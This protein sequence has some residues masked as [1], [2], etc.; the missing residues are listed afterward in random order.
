M[1]RGR[2]LAPAHRA[3][4]VALDLAVLE[5]A[6]FVAL[7][8]AVSDAEFDLGV[9]VA[10]V[11]RQGDDRHALLGGELGQLVDLALVEQALTSPFQL[12][13]QDAD[14]L[15]VGG[16]SPTEG[17][18]ATEGTTASVDRT[19]R[20]TQEA[21][22][23]EGRSGKV[24]AHHR[25]LLVLVSLM[26]LVLANPVADRGPWPGV[27][28]EAAFTLV[29]LSAAY[30]LRGQARALWILLGL[31]VP[32][33][34]LRWL[35]R[36]GIAGGVSASLADGLFAVLLAVTVWTMVRGLFHARRVTAD[37]IVSAVTVYLMLGIAFG[38]LYAI[39][40]R[41]RPAALHTPAAMTPG[42]AAPW[43][44]AMYFSFVTLTTLGYGDITPAWP[45][46]RMIAALE[47]AVGPIYLTI[48]VARL[49]TL[50]IQEQ[51]TPDDGSRSGPAR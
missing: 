8:F 1:P 39:I 29:V 46:L 31:G 44:D 33:V 28:I 26:L 15:G 38:T 47:A 32:A 7:L 11:D 12:V 16:R 4:D 20:A 24:R 25:T 2:G 50:F 14:G 34:A 3:F 48:V 40:L 18:N 10:E 30:A 36:L 23:D 35:A 6:A 43:T 41:Y 22:I 51:Q 49:V 9:A 27:L 19:V 21:Q 5:V 45:V 13:P 42:G 37:T 17:Y